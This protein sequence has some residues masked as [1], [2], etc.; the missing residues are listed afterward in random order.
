MRYTCTIIF[1]LIAAFLS[2]A[3]YVGHELEAIYLLFFALSIPAWFIPLID[4]SY[5]HPVVL[6]ILTTLVWALIGYII[7]RYSAARN[8][9]AS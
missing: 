3:H 5:P 7:D 2:V 1:A 4:D 6:Y 9:R 8:T